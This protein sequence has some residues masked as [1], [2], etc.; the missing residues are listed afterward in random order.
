MTVRPFILSAIAAAAGAVAVTPST[1][2]Y[3]YAAM[4][5]GI[6]GVKDELTNIAQTRGS[7]SYRTVWAGRITGTAARLRFANGS[8]TGAL[9]VSIDGAANATCANTGDTYTLFTGLAQAERVVIVSI[10]QAFGSSGYWTKA[11]TDALQ[12]DGAPPSI[13]VYPYIVDSMET[14]ANTVAASSYVAAPTANYRPTT[15]VV[16]AGQP[17]GNNSPSVRFRTSATEATIYTVARY[18][19]VSVDGAAPTRYDTTT[20]DGLMRT[21]RLTLSGT[22]TYNIWTNRVGGSWGQ[23]FSVGLNAATVA[24]PSKA[25]MF[26]I[27]DSTTAADTP[28]G[29]GKILTSTG[30]SD[31]FGIAATLGFAGSNNGV[32][33]KTLSGLN[34][35]IAAVLATLP[36]P[37]ASDVCV[38][39]LGR[40]DV[41][42]GAMDATRQT[43]YTNIVNA[44]LAKGFQ[45]IICRG[46]PPEGAQTWSAFNGSVQ[47]LVTGLADARVKFCDTSAWS[48]IQT[49]D[50][51]HPDDVG[52]AT[53]RGYAVA[54]YPALLV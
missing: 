50:G 25:R 30:E 53:I 36:T 51:T 37:G 42:A 15:M 1:Q 48:G 26:Q 8:P 32:S 22:H 54:T 27:G 23:A 9:L 13:Y 46:V 33:G 3:D 2:N 12:V 11:F 17:H 10:G 41:G 21:Q 40:N 7:N 43:H 47:S 28:S 6:L 49:I 5:G 29:G 14:D 45:R 16:S 39:A 20:A 38:L 44:I 35:D 24:L 18:V 19:Y 31:V 52:Y 34:T 4:A